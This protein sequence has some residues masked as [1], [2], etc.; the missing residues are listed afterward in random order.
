V[1]PIIISLLALVSCSVHA[2]K[3]PTVQ[4]VSFRAPAN[5]KIDGKA[6][7]WGAQF[8]AY[9]PATD[10]FYSL[11]NDDKK[12][13]LVFQANERF[14]IN[15]IV[16][17]GL[18]LSV[19]KNGSRNDSNVPS[20]QFPYF[21]KGSRVNFATPKLTD[22]RKELLQHALDSVMQAY[23][24]KLRTNVKWIYTK[25]IA[26]VDT[27]LSIYNDKGIEVANAFDTKRVYTCEMAID[28]KNLGLSIND[29]SKFSYHITLN[30]G[31]NKYAMDVSFGAVT[32]DDGTPAED[33]AK[34]LNHHV[35]VNEATTDF[36]GE[37]T[38]TK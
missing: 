27:V 9:N 10:I 31:P 30:G 16:N 6:D 32:N 12:L 18:K 7:E 23:N 3:L 26:D 2:Q 36:W 33:F 28:L 4:K 11:A 21:K 14:L 37:Y 15:K 22:V 29:V 13:Y 8:Q 25:G 24:T 20:V 35:K 19:Q 34:Q 5:V 1:K 38:L 17:G